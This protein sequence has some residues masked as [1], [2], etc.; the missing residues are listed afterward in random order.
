VSTFVLFVF[1]CVCL[2]LLLSPPYDAWDTGRQLLMLP[3]PSIH[4]CK[5]ELPLLLGG[6]SLILTG[7]AYDP[8]ATSLIIIFSEKE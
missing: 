3:S 2:S 1:V 4:H 5:S 7:A 8:V 6:V